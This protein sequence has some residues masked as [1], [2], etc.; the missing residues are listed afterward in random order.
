[1]IIYIV[2]DN[3]TNLDLFEAIVRKVDG[4][5]EPVCFTD[6]V[7]ALRACEQRMPDVVAVDY[8]NGPRL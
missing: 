7:E 6:P 1:M 8:T 5:L 4:A 3:E 2:D